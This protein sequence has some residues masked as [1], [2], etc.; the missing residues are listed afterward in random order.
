MKKFLYYLSISIILT[1]ISYSKNVFSKSLDPDAT[2][3]GRWR[4]IT[5]CKWDKD[6]WGG[7][8]YKLGNGKFSAAMDF[9]ILEEGG[10]K[11]FKNDRW[12]NHGDRTSKI[13]SF[14]FKK[15]SFTVKDETPW[16]DKDK[17]KGKL[18][19]NNTIQVKSSNNCKATLHRTEEISFESYAPKNL[20]DYVDGVENDEKFTIPGL[21][22]F[23][24]GDKD[25]Y[26]VMI[27]IV[28][29]GCEYN[30]RNFTYG[31][32]IKKEGVATL[33]L[34]NC[35]SRGLSRF[36]PIGAGNFNILTPWM[37]A[38]DALYALKFLQ[39]HPKVDPD[40][41]GITGFSW[42][43]QVALWTGLDII[44]KSIV[45]D[46]SDFVLRVPY[47]PYC[48]YFDDPNYSKNKLHFFIGEKDS[49]PPIYCQNMVT[50]FNKLGFDMS[51]DVFPNAYHNFDDP[52]LDSKP[53]FEPRQWFVTDKCN[54]WIAKDYTRSWR[55]N[56]MRIELDNYL[57]WNVSGDKF[58]KEYAKE[59]EKWGVKY[60]R[61]HEASKL[62]STK[63]IQLINQH[64]K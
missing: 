46:E 56:D 34:D 38:A 8:E 19:S 27:M 41:I 51:I 5:I 4:G 2:I 62:S 42:G 39:K 33:E 43:G 14:K 44:R 47:Y 30:M 3:D 6:D 50:T 52:Y 45:G 25:K 63:L 18:I 59:C 11:Q 35:K 57:D 15:N 1:T 36:N 28:N 48:R 60:G 53:Q 61:D 16:K 20:L 31:V 58:Y 23:P 7:G 10:K 9:T 12:I 24:D 29:S 40:K 21:L 26:P 22:T 49:V 17:W 32:D 54:L 13:E 55:F 37:G 64:L